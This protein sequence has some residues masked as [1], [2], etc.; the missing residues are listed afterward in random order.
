MNQ[1]ELKA[2]RDQFAE[3]YQR[4]LESFIDTHR[5]CAIGDVV[6]DELGTHYCITRID[7]SHRLE[8]SHPWLY[9]T[10]YAHAT[11]LIEYHGIR[12][13]PSGEPRGRRPY[14]VRLIPKLV[15]QRGYVPYTEPTGASL[16]ARA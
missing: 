10:E 15:V 12:C 3:Q 2:L 4:A 16:T 7:V 9:Q 11:D 6:I 13:K 8:L 1:K 14:A 5:T